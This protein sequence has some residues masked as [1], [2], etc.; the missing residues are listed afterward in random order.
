MNDVSPGGWSRHQRMCAAI[1]QRASADHARPRPRRPASANA[2]AAGRAASRAPGPAIRSTA[3]AQHLEHGRACPAGRRARGRSS[4]PPAR[5]SM[6]R[7][8]AHARRALRARPAQERRRRVAVDQ[9]VRERP[10][11]N[12]PAGHGS[13]DVARR[14]PALVA[15]M[16]HVE[17]ACPQARTARRA[18]NGPCAEKRSTSASAL[19]IVRLA[20]VIECGASCSSGSMMPRAAPPAPSTSTSRPRSPTPRLTSGRARCRRRRCCRRTSRRRATPA[21]CTR[22]PRARARCARRAMA[23]ASSLNG[24]RHVEAGPPS[25]ANARHGR[26]KPSS[27][28]SSRS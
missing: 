8:S 15:L 26:A 22:R 10:R 20:I 13:A 9:V 12:S 24:T 6:P 7:P 14:P 25:R 16:H 21:C 3:V 19:T 1:P 4:R 5:R 28:A 18:A 27:G 2:S 11:R 23:S 17:A